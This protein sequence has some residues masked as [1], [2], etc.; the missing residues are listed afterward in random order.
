MKKGLDASLSDWLNRMDGRI[1]RNVPDIY[2]DW[3]TDPV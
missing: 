2:E 3:E 1:K